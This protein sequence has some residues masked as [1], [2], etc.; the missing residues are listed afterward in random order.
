MSNFSATVTSTTRRHVEICDSSYQL[1]LGKLG[2]R[3][4]NVCVGDTVTCKLVN[5]EVAVTAVSDRKNIIS[6]SYQGKVKDLAANI[7]HL[8]IVT[9]VGPLFNSTFIDRVLAVARAQKVPVT[10]VV[11]KVD[12]QEDHNQSI[13]QIKI[14]KE[15]DLPVVESSAVSNIGIELLI[16]KIMEPEIKIVAFTGVSGVGKSSIINVLIPKARSRTNE[17]SSRT[18][19]GRQTTT[20]SLAHP[21][22]PEAP[23]KFL[24]DMPG[25]QKFGISHLSEDEVRDSLVEFRQHEKLCK[26]SDC[27]HLIEADCEVVRAL[28][29]GKIPPSRYRSYCDMN[30]E[31]KE[32]KR[33]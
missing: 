7:D 22:P 20:Q 18:G 10:L 31:I 4:F 6:R 14:Y 30:A 29:A 26:F 9:A 24:I 5:D 23:S 1:K 15:I 25:V 11:N 13:D 16:S 33:Y 21:Y 28:K 12:Q 27:S 17:V 19:Q 8:F 32:S 3:S 2:S